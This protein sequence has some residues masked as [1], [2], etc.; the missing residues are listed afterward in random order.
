MA[1]T[2]CPLY[3]MWLLPS[4]RER[5]LLRIAMEILNIASFIIG[6]I[7][8]VLAV[9]Q[10]LRIRS[11]AARNRAHAWRLAK[12]AHNL[13]A[14]LEGM[15]ARLA[16]GKLR[17]EGESAAS[18]SQELSRSYELSSSLV[19]DMAEYLVL[20]FDVSEQEIEARASSGDVWGY[21]HGKLRFTVSSVEP[22]K[23][24]TAQKTREETQ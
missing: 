6:V 12:K 21:F 4:N 3:A 24:E 5:S 14:H 8:I 13:M 17:F 9:V 15:H 19:E 11:I 10:Q 16:E 23:A 20:E 7:G 22:G 2:R 1:P 18:D